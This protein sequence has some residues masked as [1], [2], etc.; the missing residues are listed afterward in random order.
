MGVLS[1]AQRKLLSDT[2]A[3]ARDVLDLACAQRIASLGVA[4]E[5]VPD[6]LNEKDRILRRA[7]RARA[8]QLGSVEALAGE[9][10]YEHWHRMLFA[11]YLADNHLL[12]D[13]QTS[14]AVSIEEIAEYAAEIG[15]ADVWEVAARFAAAMLPGI[16]SQDDPVLQMRL[17]VETRQRLEELLASLPENVI[18][19]DDSIG[20]VYQYWQARRKDEVNRAEIKIGG[21]NLAPVTQLF[22]EN[23]M[24]DFLLQNSLG[25]WWALRHPD[26]L[27]LA[28]WR[29]L[30]FVDGSPSTA[31]A[32]SGWPTRVR[33]IT[34]LDPCCGSGHFLVATF[35]MLWRMRAEEE[36]LSIT[37]AQDAVLRENLFGLELDPRCVQIATFSLAIS[38]WKTGGYRLL[39]TPNVACAGIPAKSPLSDWVSLADGDLQLEGAL[40]RLHSLF[41]NADALGSLIDPVRAAEEAGL[42]SVDW[43]EVA[44]LLE[45]A[46]GHA[47]VGVADPAAAVFG[48]A[49]AGLVK[50][51]QLLTRKYSVIA[52][53][54]PFLS[55]R[56]MDDALSAYVQADYPMASRDLST[57]MMVRARRM[58][59]D[60]GVSAFI[61]PHSWFYL[62]GYSNMRKWACAQH[63]PALIAWLG[64]G[65]FESISGEVVNV[66]AGIYGSAGANPPRYNAINVSAIRGV[67]AKAAA[68]RAQSLVRMTSNGSSLPLVDVVEGST[69]GDFAGSL[70]G[71][72]TGDDPRNRFKFWELSTDQLRSWRLEVAS[73][74]ATQPFTGRYSAVRWPSDDYYQNQSSAHLHA[75]EA[76]GRPSVIV[77]LMGSLPVTLYSGD[78]WH[79]NCARLVPR[80]VEDL[81]ALWAFCSSDEFEEAVRAVDH[82][83]K[84]TPASLKKVP[85]DLQRWR[86]VAAAHYPSGLPEPFS[87]DPTQ[88]LFAGCAERSSSPLH[89]AVARLLGF[90]WPEQTPDDSDAL[91]D[92]DGIVC[93]PAVGGERPAV[94]RLTELLSISYGRE[95]EPAALDS[96]LAQCG[97]GNGTQ[98]LETWLRNRFFTEHTKLFANRPFIWHVWDGTPGGFAALLNYHKLDRRLLE[99]LTYDYLGSWWLGRVRDQI[100]QGVLGAEKHL[101]A[102]EML[103]QKLQAILDG[104]KPFDIYVRWKSLSEQAL[105]WDPDLNDG[106]RLNIRPFVIA[107]ILRHQP[108]LNWN[109]DRGKNPDGSD[110][111]NDLHYTLAERRAA[112]GK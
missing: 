103:K 45:Q 39:P 93:L 7:L 99:R 90:A 1:S 22:T 53:N 65:A 30:R 28:E 60:Y 88:W 29:Y 55:S 81:P 108:V 2:V 16:F 14:Q 112:R 17:P 8:R 15:E 46:L 37:A 21:E 80:N 74:F 52:T 25:A 71:L 43:G 98:G 73:D 19:A 100:E 95:W 72:Q 20:W 70:T 50:A 10:A 24:V 63:Q 44:P 61:T 31:I 38:A 6:S 102:A 40:T 54:P 83:L 27:L 32:F 92:R 104:D 9:A 4:Q 49:A 26:S 111:V 109:K 66:V 105:G 42:E 36:N 79:Q 11:R 34:L 64:P 12:V 101:A 69:L 41:V 67:E 5:R 89:V 75:R 106:V 107:G 77:R 110:R 85:F 87:D 13:D 94:E 51:A 33:E 35:D 96:L 97:G 82:S 76:A 62:R 58:L 91:S 56:R 48:E 23:Y 86:E 84:I 3:D 47:V 59:E 18:T 78:V 68:L 57:C